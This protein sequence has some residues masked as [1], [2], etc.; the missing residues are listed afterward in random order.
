MFFVC[1]S[2]RSF[3]ATDSTLSAPFEACQIETHRVPFS[4][5]FTQ[6]SEN[7]LVP[8]AGGL[9]AEPACLTW[10]LVLKEEVS[11]RL[12]KGLHG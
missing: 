5:S 7:V 3:E 9:R 12:E 8:K 10:T 2:K 11:R 6:P 1:H 4:F